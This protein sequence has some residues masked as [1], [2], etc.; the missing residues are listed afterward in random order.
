MAKKVKKPG[1]PLLDKEAQPQPPPDTEPVEEQQPPKKRKPS[2]K[3]T[4]Q[5]DPPKPAEIKALAK[6]RTKLIDDIIERMEKQ[7]GTA[8]DD[9]LRRIVDEFV[10]K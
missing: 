3:Q 9:L 7:V 4:A 6:E 10:E 1:D 5:E 2:I 8:Q